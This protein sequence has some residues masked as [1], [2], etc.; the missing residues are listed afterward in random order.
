MEN[1]QQEKAMEKQGGKQPVGSGSEKQ[2]LEKTG[3]K[4]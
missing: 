4:G 3:G 2:L 1:N